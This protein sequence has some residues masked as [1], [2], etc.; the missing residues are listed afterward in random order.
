[1]HEEALYL[2]TKQL[3]RRIRV[4]SFLDNFYLAGG[5]ALALQLG[6][7]KSV[8]LDFFSP[9]FPRQE[10]LLQELSGYNPQIAQQA[11]GT[12][13]TYISGVKVGFFEY[14]YPLLEPLVKYE[15]VQLAQVLDIACMKLSAITS[16]GA[17]KD[18]VDLYVILQKHKLSELIEAFEKK[19]KGLRYN[20]LHLLKSLVYFEDA[21]KD[22]EPDYLVKLRWTEIKKYLKTQAKT[23]E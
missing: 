10:Q 15:T 1:M 2:N 23:L 3:L 16:R 22:P 6:H 7:R 11:K 14:K 19:Y 5:T 13:D 4:E 9:I 21:D 20:K 17:K 18:F 8:D 12:L